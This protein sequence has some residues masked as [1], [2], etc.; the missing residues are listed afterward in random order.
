VPRL[1]GHEHLYLVDIA[2]VAVMHVMPARV[3]DVPELLSDPQRWGIVRAHLEPGA[4]QVEVIEHVPMQRERSIPAISLAPEVRV[5]EELGEIEAVAHRPHAAACEPNDSS[6]GFDRPEHR[7][8]VLGDL[9]E[10]LLPCRGHSRLVP[11][12]VRVPHAHIGHPP[13]VDIEIRLDR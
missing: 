5:D 8:L 10:P 12:A 2:G 3:F 1:L 11:Y 6:F 7:L 9:L 13:V 4:P